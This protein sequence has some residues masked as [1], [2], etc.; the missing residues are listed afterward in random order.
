M[1]DEETGFLD[2]TQKS[3]TVEYLRNS[4]VIV[5]SPFLRHSHSSKASL[6]FTSLCGG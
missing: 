1:T 3:L 4:S 6:F 2:L 5:S